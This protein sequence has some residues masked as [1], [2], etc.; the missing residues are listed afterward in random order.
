MNVA[1]LIEARTNVRKAKNQVR[2]A[3]VNALPALN[4]LLTQRL[5]ELDAA[6]T[7]LTDTIYAA[8]HP[9]AAA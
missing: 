3:R 6:E 4:A 1:D 5:A 8:Q 9:K 2:R 7:A